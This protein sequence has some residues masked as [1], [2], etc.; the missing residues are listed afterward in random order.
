MRILHIT[1]HMG[2][3]VGKAISG[4][5]LSDDRNKHKI[6]LLDSPEKMDHLM[7]CEQRGIE[8]TVCPTSSQICK[9]VLE[10]DV[11]V[12]NWWHHPLIYKALMELSGIP[13]RV[14]LWSHVNG[15]NY[16]KLKPEFARYFDACMFTSKASFQN[17]DWSEEEK[18]CIHKKSELVYGMGDFNP[19]AFKAK[20]SYSLEQGPK[21]GY[22]GSLDYAKLHPDFANWLK[23][24]ANCNPQVRFMVA[25]DLIKALEEDV[26][27]AGISENVEFLGFR[28]DIAEL[29]CTWDIFIYPLNPVNFATTEN[30]LLEAMAA[31]LPIVV[32]DGIVERSIIDDGETGFLVSDEYSF[33]E[34]VNEL[35]E[36]EEL[37]I[38]LGQRARRAVVENYDSKANF[39]RFLAVM[40]TVM[41]QTKEI[42][43]FSSAIGNEAFQWFLV[44]C[45][46]D[47]T[48]LM[49]ELSECKKETGEWK[50]AANGTLRLEKIYKGES[51]GSARQFSRYYPAD[52]RLETLTKI[53]EE[54]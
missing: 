11:V 35:L 52:K 5:A 43:D 36:N 49:E 47:E 3:G 20:Q 18:N 32:S 21:V 15:L 29:L 10:A 41:K 6:I 12:V 19:R 30:A 9:E 42:H 28:M 46:N 24:T 25:G 51:K 4:L 27:K 14:V 33:A 22:V 17:P 50:K 7:R 34:R 53:M 31:G 26:N 40:D 1:A 16:P 23:E 48:E 54:I 37:R 45:G 38:S 8:V 39:E 13:A 2:A 44:G